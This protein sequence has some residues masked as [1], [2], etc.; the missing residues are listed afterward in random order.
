MQVQGAQLA[1]GKVAYA[2]KGPLDALW[3]IAAREGWRTLFKASPCFVWW[4]AD[5]RTRSE[6]C[7]VN[8]EPLM[9]HQGVALMALPV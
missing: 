1:A 3:T 6:W 7:L 8:P 2:Y 9:G 5:L 4:L